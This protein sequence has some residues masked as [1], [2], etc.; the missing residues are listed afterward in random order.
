MSTDSKSD[1]YGRMINQNYADYPAVVKGFNAA[2]IASRGNKGG[3]GGSSTSGGSSSSG[4]S[5]GVPAGRVNDTNTEENERFNDL[6]GFAWA[7]TA[8]NRLAEKNIIN[9][10]DDNKFEPASAVL[11]EE[12]VKMIVLAAGKYDESAQADFAD[13]AKDAWHYSYV[14][15]AYK[16]NIVSGM[17][18][19]SFGIGQNITREDMAVIMARLMGYNASSDK[20][21]ADFTDAVD[22]SD[23]AVTAVAYVSK[24][25]LV[26][27]TDGKFNPKESLTRAEAAVVLNRFLSY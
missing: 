1:I 26:E 10:R 23:Y 22:I 19:G 5:S 6:S 4:S 21:T 16:N 24:M 25:G 13:V 17:D 11:R 27:G 9:G 15:S 8:I 3:G 7:K 14:A 18:N 20:Y 2:I 12:F